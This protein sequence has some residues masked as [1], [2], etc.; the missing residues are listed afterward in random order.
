M[1]IPLRNHHLQSSSET[2]HQQHSLLYDQHHDES[3]NYHR[4][5]KSVFSPK[6][7]PT[8]GGRKKLH[9]SLPMKHYCPEQIKV[10]LQHNYLIVQGEHIP[11]DKTHSDNAYFYKSVIL[12][13]GIQTDHLQSQLTH[14]GHL[15]IEAPF[16]EHKSNNRSE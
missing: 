14:D 1:D 6:I 8:D 9:M 16:I 15:H 3:F 7:I 12:P 5:H 11:K 10:S 2:S 4:F 13:P